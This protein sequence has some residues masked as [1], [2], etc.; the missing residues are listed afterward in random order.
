[1]KERNLNNIHF[2]WN[3]VNPLR[4]RKQTKEVFGWDTETY[5]GKVTLICVVGKE[6]KKHLIVKNIDELLKFLTFRRFTRGH[7]FF[8][9]VKYDRDAIFKLLP[10]ENINELK[11]HDHT[12]YKNYRISLIGNKAFT[13]STW[14]I[15]DKEGLKGIR[16]TKT[17]FFS[18]IGVFY[19]CGSLEKTVREGLGKKYVKRLDASQGV[20]LSEINDEWIDY[21]YEDAEWTFKLGENIND[22]VKE[23]DI[24]INRYYSPASIS[25]AF[26]RLRFPE[27]YEFKKTAIQQYA[28]YGFNAGRFEVLKKGF[29]DKV[30]MCDICSAYPEQISKLYYP[31]GI[32]V[33]NQEYE[34]E[35]L[36]SYYHVNIEVP[37]DFIF[38][39]YR[40]SLPHLNNLLAFP[41]GKFDSVYLCKSEYEILKNI[42][43]K[44]EIISAKHIFN[45][46]PR[47]WIEGVAEMYYKRKELKKLGDRKE[48]L[49]KILMNSWYGI[50]IQENKSKIISTVFSDED[51]QNPEVEFIVAKNGDGEEVINCIKP[52]WRAGAWFNPILG[53]EIPTRTRNKIYNDF[54]KYE[55]SIIQVAT[56][57]I[58]MTS[59]L[60]VEHSTDL[61]GYEHYPLMEGF[62]LGNGIYKFTEK[63]TGKFKAGTRGLL[64]DNEIEL[65]NL[66]NG[67]FDNKITL[68]KTRPKSLR[69]GIPRNIKTDNPNELINIFM[70]YDRELDVNVDKKREWERDFL[71]FDEVINGEMINSLPLHF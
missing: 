50:C 24:P 48:H 6:Y 56:D 13:I 70:P 7:N 54:H 69:E 53:N 68:T 10:D 14:S 5:K 21:C 46:E 36:Y 63:D 22:M 9:N 65:Y 60:P 31:E 59:R 37:E 20:S 35:A 1:M 44:I 30:Y 29:F 32:H 67:C 26:L 12:F 55:D 3:K 64:S 47:L 52:L 49:L 66:F 15:S 57:S 17:A 27:G 11:Y 8:F 38:S 51:E 42:D 23:M 58:A 40:H 18:D 25:K 45:N 19:Q 71:N 39:P 28:L 41:V 61:G 34:P 33:S 43:A 4:R 16:S 62:V 2:G